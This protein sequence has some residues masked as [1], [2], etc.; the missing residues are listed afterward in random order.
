MAYKTFSLK[1]SSVQLNQF[2]SF[3]AEGPQTLHPIR[4]KSST[5]DRGAIQDLC[6]ELFVPRPTNQSPTELSMLNQVES[7]RAM[8]SSEV[9][10]SSTG[11][12]FSWWLRFISVFL[13]TLLLL[14]LLNMMVT[15][16]LAYA[17]QRTSSKVVRF[18]LTCV[19]EKRERETV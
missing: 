18:L 10:S 12:S 2:S 3:A 14:R 17:H 19:R 13:L 5:K 11:F 16:C 1:L 9:D 6:P 7:G 15:H 8:E 4:V